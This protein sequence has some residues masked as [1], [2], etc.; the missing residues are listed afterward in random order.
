MFLFSQLNNNDRLQSIKNIK[1]GI[2]CGKEK[3]FGIVVRSFINLKSQGATNAL[4]QMINEL[5]Q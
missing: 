4:N 1:E 5:I 3:S 2:V